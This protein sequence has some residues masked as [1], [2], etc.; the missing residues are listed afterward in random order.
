[1]RLHHHKTLPIG[2]DIGSTAVRMIQLEIGAEG[3]I[4]IG[5]A[6]EEIPPEL[7]D[8]IPPGTVPSPAMLQSVIKRAY[9]QG[10][11]IGKRIVATLPREVVQVKSVRLPV[12]PID[13]LEVAGKIEAEQALGLAPGA[14]EF[15]ILPAGEIRQGSETR[16]EV[17]LLGAANSHLE[18]AIESWN[19]AGFV[20]A[21]LEYEP[22][23]L[24]RAVERFVRRRD[25]QN[26]V[27]VIVDIGFRRT[28]VVIGRGKEMCFVKA[29]EIGG[30]QIIGAIA[31]KLGVSFADAATLRSRLIATASQS[32]LVQADPVRQA[33]YDSVRPIVDELA[34][35]LAL[36]LRHYTVTF[37]GARPARIRVVGGESNDPMVLQVLGSV[38]PVP[39][40]AS[41]FIANADMSRMKAA[42]RNERAGDWS[43]A[44]GL[45]LRFTEGGFPD[46]LGAP[47][48]AGVAANAGT[49]TPVVP[50]IPDDLEV[51]ELTT[52]PR[53]DAEVSHA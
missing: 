50:G 42:D 47:R 36:C 3:P 26:D 19:T 34:R 39:I 48:A 23:S 53:A 13:E 14:A 40:E 5:A 4:V 51:P 28:H 18:A 27:N 22:S 24:Y 45:A 8:R 52:R 15:R 25:D 35:E 46:R 1:M 6:R 33:V 37:R 43:L 10:G 11:F 17:F 12:M 2:I 44:F 9:Q 41:R 16:L 32:P 7:L 29:I 49:S 31:R 21:S 38:V 20:P 30:K